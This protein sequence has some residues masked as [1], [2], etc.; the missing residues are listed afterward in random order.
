MA[1]RS[2]RSNTSAATDTTSARFAQADDTGRARLYVCAVGSYPVT[3]DL[4]RPAKMAP[5]LFL[6][7]LILILVSWIAGS[8]SGL[9]LV[10]LGFPV[11]A[12]ILVS[13]KGGE[14]YLAEDS[15]PRDRLGRVH[16][17]RPCL[18]RSPN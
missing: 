17:R 14:R 11:A 3:F 1:C 7:I 4:E 13:Q 12:A 6:R 2:A 16:R 15:G 10:Y 9:G 5:D 18:H 8:G